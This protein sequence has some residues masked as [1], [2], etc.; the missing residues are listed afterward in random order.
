MNVEQ[1]V[2]L[3]LNVVAAIAILIVGWVVAGWAEK[4]VA[5][6]TKRNDK[7]DATLAVVFA[8]VVR[9]AVLVFTII[10]VL[11]RFGVQTASLVA[12][13]GAA[14]LAIGLAL[15][16]ALS[17][18]AAGVMLLGLRPFR[19]GDA[20]DIGG[21]AGTVDDMGLF[22]TKMRTFEGVPVFMPNGRIWGNEIKNFSRAERRRIDLTIGVGYGDDL[23]QALAVLGQV[24]AAEP[25]VL[26]DPEPLIKVNALGASSV[27]LLVRVWTLPA[28]FLATQMDLT[29]A[30]KQRF[31]AEGITIPFPQQD[32]HY[33]PAELPPRA[34]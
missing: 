6:T 21:T 31:D 33:V 19:I 25:R 8:R 16:G 17:N 13:L 32:V 27:D 26:T 2:D 28:D 4:V 22:V 9:W 10:A 15:Q 12:L 5:G 24:V 7:I 20:V 14:G 34:A 23:D 30:I 18:V 1:I 29:K 3:G 11:D